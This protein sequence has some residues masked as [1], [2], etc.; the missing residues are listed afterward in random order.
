MSR[1]S[2]GAAPGHRFSCWHPVDGPAEARVADPAEVGTTVPAGARWP[3][4]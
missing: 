4:A 3:R 2:T 1:R